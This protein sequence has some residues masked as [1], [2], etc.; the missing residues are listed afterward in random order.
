[1]DGSR[2]PRVSRVKFAGLSSSATMGG[3]S[4]NIAVGGA[5]I[6]TFEIRFYMSPEFV[7]YH[8]LLNTL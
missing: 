1:M 3:A 2:I 4:S 7:A 8:G 5:P 6:K